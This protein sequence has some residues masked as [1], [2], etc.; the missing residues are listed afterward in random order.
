M[1]VNLRI[2]L[3]IFSLGFALEAGVDLFHVLTGSTT[4][5]AGGSLFLLGAVATVLG[6][7]F[8]WVGRHEWNELHRQRVR[9]AHLT[10]VGVLVLGAAAAAPPAYFAY[11]NPTR[12]PAWLGPEVGAAVALSLLVTV[13]MYVVVVLHLVGPAGKAVLALALLTAV[14]VSYYIGLDVARDLPKYIAAATAGPTGVL[15]IAEPVLGLFS[16]L[17]ASYFFLLAAFAEAHHRVARGLIPAV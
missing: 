6:L 8:L 9:H 2:S 17:F 12:L 11:A 1:T 15:P 7:L 16:W 4:L 14:P 3:T 10:F 5:I 13:A